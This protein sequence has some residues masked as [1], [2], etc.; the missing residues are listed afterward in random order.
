MP[1]ALSNRISDPVGPGQFVID[2]YVANCDAQIKN[3]GA[4][5]AA[6]EGLIEYTLDS[7]AA[8]QGSTKVDSLSL[9]LVC[10]AQGLSFCD[11]YRKLV[12]SSGSG[13][14]GQDMPWSDTNMAVL[15]T[16]FESNLAV[17]CLARLSHLVQE[18]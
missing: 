16:L 15:M 13:G 5:I 14:H 6:S 2:R 3:S 1:A 4:G 7:V 8:F 9:Q 12:I 11:V 18:K 10:L 17:Q